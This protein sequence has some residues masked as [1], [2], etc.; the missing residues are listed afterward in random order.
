MKCPKCNSEINSNKKFCTQCGYNIEEFVKEEKAKKKA[1]RGEKIYKVKMKIFIVLLIIFAISIIVIAGLS[2]F[3]KKSHESKEKYSI[4]EEETTDENSGVQYEKTNLEIELTDE[5]RQ[6]DYDNDGLTNEKEA[7]YGTSMIN[8]DTDGDGLNDYEE[9]TFYH[10]DPTKYSTSDDGISDYIKAKRNLK[11]D[12]KYKPSEVKPEEVTAGF[13]ITLIPD[14]LESQ[15]YGGLEEFGRDNNVNSTQNVFD[16]T[17][18]KGKVEYTTGREDSILLIREGKHYT[19]FKNYK[20]EKGKLIIT[21]TEEDNY[22][23]FVIT[24]KENYENYKNK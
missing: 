1:E 2:F 13:N 23:D 3:G 4:I 12:Q 11:M 18:F 9:I 8:S 6:L 24:T 19:E 7:E 20:N 14:D 5:N 15:Y 16:L 17:N 21:I 22:K 10:S